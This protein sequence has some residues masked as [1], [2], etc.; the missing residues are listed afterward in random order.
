[1]KLFKNKPNKREYTRD[2]LPHNR[3]EVFFDVLKLQWKSLLGL[4]GIVLL[5]FIPLIF[6]YAA[7]NTYASI[8]LDNSGAIQGTPE[9]NAVLNQ[10]NMLSNIMAFVRIPFFVLLSVV[11]GG[12]ARV[13]RQ[14]A[15]EECVSFSYDFPEGIKQNAKG[16]ALLAL[17]TSSVF[18][19]SYMAFG[20]RTVTDEVFGVVCAFPI[21]LYFVVFIPIAAVVAVLIPVYNNSFSRNLKWALYIFAKKP[22]RIIIS[23]LLSMSVFAL[24]LVP[25][26]IVGL[27]GLVVGAML[28]PVA[29]LGFYLSTFD[30]LDEYINKDNFPEIVGKGTF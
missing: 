12:V 15:Y 3:K 25:G 22:L 23:L 19:L 26:F 2:M 7:E 17:L 29:M 20:L 4:G 24:S 28:I 6:C 9:Y 1:M 21:A 5:A 8:M 10:I 18:A 30:V 14:H 13:V 27:I 11:L 16:A